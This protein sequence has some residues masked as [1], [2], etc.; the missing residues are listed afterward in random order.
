MVL[1]STLFSAFFSFFFT[2]HSLLLFHRPTHRLNNKVPLARQLPLWHRTFFILI[3]LLQNGSKK[4]AEAPGIFASPSLGLTLCWSGA[5]WIEMTGRVNLLQVHPELVHCS[6]DYTVEVHSQSGILVEDSGGFF[7][8]F[9]KSVLVGCDAQE[10]WSE[11]QGCCETIFLCF[12]I[13]GT[14]FTAGFDVGN[15]L[16][17]YALGF[18][19]RIQ[20]GMI[21]VRLYRYLV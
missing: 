21:F 16:D 15:C 19:S 4:G 5:W 2:S 12:V 3:I 18:W 8:V 20:E 17:G 11:L 7:S 13:S 10:N 9:L 6:P 1:Y 14:Q